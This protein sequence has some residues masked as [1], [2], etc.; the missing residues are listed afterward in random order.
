MITNSV[1]Y[2]NHPFDNPQ[3]ACLCTKLWRTLSEKGNNTSIVLSHFALCSL[4]LYSCFLQFITC[5]ML[6]S[7]EKIIFSAR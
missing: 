7:F 5:K 6:V 4:A 2:L 3:S 1:Q